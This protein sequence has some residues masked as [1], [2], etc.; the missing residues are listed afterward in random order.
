MFHASL[1]ER[2]NFGSLSVLFRRH[3]GV[4]L[5]IYI[6]IYVQAGLDDV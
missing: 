3:D 1:L 5:H 6:Y 2:R 4:E